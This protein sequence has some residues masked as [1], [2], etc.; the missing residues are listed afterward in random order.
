MIILSNFKL[1]AKTDRYYSNFLDFLLG[2]KSTIEYIGFFDRRAVTDY[3]IANFINS[4]AG[5]SDT[6]YV[7]GNNAQLYKMTDRIPLHRYTVLY[8]VTNYKDGYALTVRAL[9]S[10]KPRF[11]VVMQNKELL[12]ISLYNYTERMKIE[13]ATIYERAN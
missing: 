11:I 6:I 10:E 5:A 2:K 3:K 13:N 9:N 4:K 7:W 8:H 12:P 1:Y